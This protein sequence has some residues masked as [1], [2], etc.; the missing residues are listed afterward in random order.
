MEPKGAYGVAIAWA[1][2]GR[3]SDIYS[4]DALRTVAMSLPVSGGALE[5]SDGASGWQ[6]RMIDVQT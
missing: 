6:K 5:G 3:T 2:A 4:F 1:D